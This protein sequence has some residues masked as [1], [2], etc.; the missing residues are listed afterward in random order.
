MH[1]EAVARH[2]LEAHD[3]AQAAVELARGLLA[4]LDWWTV[5][6][7]EGEAPSPECLE[8]FLLPLLGRVTEALREVDAARAALQ[9]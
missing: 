2:L 6:D 7:H 5:R 1:A 3:A 9:P 8:L 4:A